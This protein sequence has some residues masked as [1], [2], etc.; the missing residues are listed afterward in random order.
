MYLFYLNKNK[1]K[2]HKT[3]KQKNISNENTLQIKK[4]KWCK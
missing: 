3:N 2:I 1:N 4:L